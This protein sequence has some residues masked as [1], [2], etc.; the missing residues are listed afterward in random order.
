MP[1]VWPLDPVT[2]TTRNLA[3]A[4]VITC[5]RGLS[6]AKI[7]SCTPRPTTT[8]F[9]FAETSSAVRN[10]PL[11]TETRWMSGSVSLVPMTTK[12]LDRFWCLTVPPPM[13]TPFTL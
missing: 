11:A 2:P 1:M 13:T 7:V 8:A 5:P 9:R 3:P 4:T 12:S 10:R 6:R